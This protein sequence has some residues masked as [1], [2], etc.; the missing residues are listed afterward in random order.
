MAALSVAVLPIMATPHSE[1]RGYT[2][3]YGR[4]TLTMAILTV[5]VLPIMATL[6]P[7]PVAVLPITA[8]PRRRLGPL[9]TALQ[10]TDALGLAVF[11]A[12]QVNPNPNPH[13]NPDPNP[14]PAAFLATQVD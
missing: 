10:E 4:A 12:T 5:V 7:R 14:N 1:N 6:T 8:G 13:S 3:C 2:F 9:A 11:L